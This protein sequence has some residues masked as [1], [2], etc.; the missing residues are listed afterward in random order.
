MHLV[1]EILLAARTFEKKAQLLFRPYGLTPAQFNVLNCL[2]DQ[3]DGM[4]ASDLARSL[5]V[6]PSNVTGMLKRMKKEGLVREIANPGDRRQHVVA[7]SAKGLEAWT[8]CNRAYQRSLRA[9]DSELT[10]HERLVGEAAVR[11]LAHKAAD[12]ETDK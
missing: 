9:L 4:R 10:A 12:L 3:P 5:I 6:D 11:K 1:V 8:R 7:L 2:S